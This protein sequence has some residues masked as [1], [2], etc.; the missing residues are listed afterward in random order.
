MGNKPNEGIMKTIKPGEAT[1]WNCNTCGKEILVDLLAVPKDVEGNIYC[2]AC[3]IAAYAN[4]LTLGKPVPDVWD[5]T[6]G[7]LD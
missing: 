1:K 4:D 3:G 5:T 7:Y 2:W 6:R